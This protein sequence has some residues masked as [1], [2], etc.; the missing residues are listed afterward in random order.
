MLRILFYLMA[1]LP[2]GARRH[3][4]R[5]LMDTVW[6]VLAEEEVEG[7]DN[8]PDEPCLFIANHLSNA[9]GFTLDRAFRPRKVIFLAGVKLQGTTMTRLAS[10]VMDTIAIK[11]N[12]ADIEAMRRAVETLKGGDS[13]LIFPE[14]ARSRTGELLQAKKGV[15]LIAK[16]AG[17]PVVPVA[18][19]G[20]EKLM[21]I[22]DQ[23][24]GGERLYRARVLVRFGKP[25]RVEDLEA[26]A[27]GA[28]DARQG[29]VDAMM[30]R[31][32]ELLPPEYRGVYADAPLQ[33]A[34]GPRSQRRGL[35]PEQPSAPA[36]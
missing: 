5:A 15:S 20:T 23:D 2:E 16:R 12:S 7:R 1:K 24:M 25:F 17:V 18:L 4:V 31:V 27:A 21:P 6:D 35:E 30:R 28:Q 3:V 29:L 34:P 36:P 14:G 22:N 10:E 8:I 19:R 13:V 33:A 11:P 32:A 26:E 9:D